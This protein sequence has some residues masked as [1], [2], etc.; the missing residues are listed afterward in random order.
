[1]MDT[2]NIGRSGKSVIY[3]IIGGLGVLTFLGIKG[4]FGREIER[5]ALVIVSAYT[6][7]ANVLLFKIMFGRKK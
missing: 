6:L 4:W 1:M 3:T 2:R 7:Y 5:V